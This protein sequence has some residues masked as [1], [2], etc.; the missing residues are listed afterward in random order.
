MVIA[1]FLFFLFVISIFA[2]RSWQEKQLKKAES[3]YELTKNDRDILRKKNLK[4][5]DINAA[6]SDRVEDLFELYEITKELTKYRNLNDV[7]SFF[8]ES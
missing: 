2:V 4:I 7:F 3:A 1:G 5:E 8:R 6:L